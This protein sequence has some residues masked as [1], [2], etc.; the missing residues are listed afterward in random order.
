MVCVPEDLVFAVTEF[1]RRV[2]YARAVARDVA[3]DIICRREVGGE[4]GR[5]DDAAM[6]PCKESLGSDRSTIP[7]HVVHESSLMISHGRTHKKSRGH[8]KGTLGHENSPS[9][10]SAADWD[11]RCC[12]EQRGGC[13]VYRLGY[14]AELVEY[15]D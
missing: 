12:S 9:L 7:V 13:A 4:N 10:L 15:N 2:D 14:K 8:E 11:S 6:P 3:V 1:V 5:V